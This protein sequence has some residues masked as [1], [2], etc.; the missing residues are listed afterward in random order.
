MQLLLLLE[1]SVIQFPAELLCKMAVKQHEHMY[2]GHTSRKSPCTPLM[3]TCS[4][5]FLLKWT[6][7]T[8]SR[9]AAR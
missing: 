3:V 6:L 7:M 9:T 8:G 4:V 5:L 2:L 1:G